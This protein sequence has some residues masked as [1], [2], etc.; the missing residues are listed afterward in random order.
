MTFYRVDALPEREIAPGFRA[1]FVHGETM[2]AAFWTADAGAELPE[3]RHP[4]EQTAQVLAGRFALTVDGE[5]REMEPGEVAMIPP[6]APHG[7]RALTDCRLLDV[8]SPVREDY[9]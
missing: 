9:R 2:T 6:D 4:H 7:G 8:F 1:R 3:H 5:T